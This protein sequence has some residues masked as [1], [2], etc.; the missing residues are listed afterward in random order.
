MEQVI[1]SGIGTALLLCAAGFLWPR[2]G[3]AKRKFVCGLCLLSVLLPPLFSWVPLLSESDAP[4]WTTGEAESFE[5]IFSDY[6]SGGVRE[7]AEEAIAKRLCEQFGVK[8]EN[9]EIGLSVGGDLSLERVVIC[10]R[11]RDIF[12]SPYEIETYFS[13]L[14]GCE[15]VV[16]T[17]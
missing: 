10:L 7:K 6:L 13:D 8:P 15:C 3:E 17:G 11:G 2:S 14:L 9:V 1:T 16:V 4:P 12:R 5:K